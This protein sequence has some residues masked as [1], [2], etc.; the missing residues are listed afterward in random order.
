[1]WSLHGE[2]RCDRLYP[3]AGLH[4]AAS[5]GLSPRPEAWPSPFPWLQRLIGSCRDTSLLPARGAGVGEEPHGT[6]CR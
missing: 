1:M 6:S 2:R 4:P 3:A 5:P